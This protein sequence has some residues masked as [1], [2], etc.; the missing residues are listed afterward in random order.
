M[1]K[2]LL[3]T[4]LLLATQPIAALN[5]SDIPFLASVFNKKTENFWAA[6]TMIIGIAAISLGIWWPFSKKTIATYGH[7][8]RQGRRP[9]MEDAFFIENNADHAFFG[10]FDG[11]GGRAVADYLAQNLYQ[12]IL[13][14]GNFK[15]DPVA[16]IRDGCLATDQKLKNISGLKYIT[17]GS[18][19]VMALIKSGKISIGN[20]GD[21]RA[22]LA[23]NGIAQAL[24]TDH[25][26]N[27]PSEAA[28][29]EAAGGSVYQRKINNQDDAWRVYNASRSAGGLAVSRAFGDFGMKNFG[30]IAEPEIS[31]HTITPN[32]EFLILACDGVW[33][34]LDNQTA[35]DVVK[36]SLAQ[37]PNN[38]DAAAK[39]L[40]LKA[41]AFGSTD[42]VS[43]II[44]KLN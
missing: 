43:A 7:A 10:L 25:K 35:V 42:N 20:V 6:A 44:I 19:A 16:A 33:D 39:A 23:S 37:K 18:T 27:I 4:S 36:A 11:H 29:I 14:D 40:T 2:I 8:E 3:I 21:S 13:Q 32:D 41:L 9:T 5:W 28:R 1:K 31:I 26:P 22:V 34:V 17:V 38:F 24:S 12:N 30:L 15:A